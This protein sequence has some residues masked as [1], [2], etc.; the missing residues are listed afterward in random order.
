MLRRARVVAVAQREESREGGE[1]GGGE[2]EVR[3]GSERGERGVRGERAG[4]GL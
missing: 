1:E 4:E 2:M 3:V